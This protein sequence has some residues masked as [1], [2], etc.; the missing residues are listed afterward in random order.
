MPKHHYFQ[1]RLVY[2]YIISYIL[3]FLIPFVFMSLYVYYQSS[4]SLREEIESSNVNKLEQIESITNERIK[5]LE[6]TASKIAFS[7]QLTPYKISHRYYG[8]EAI[9]ELSNLKDNNAIIHELFIY[10]YEQEQLLYSSQGPYSFSELLQRSYRFEEVTEEELKVYL[11]SDIPTVMS[12]KKVEFKNGT[13]DKMMAF[14]YPISP[15]NP[16]PYGAI[17]YFVEESMLTNLT[18]N[19][20]GD[21]QGSTYIVDENNQ[22]IVSASNGE[23]VSWEQLNQ[24]SFQQQGVRTITIDNR[25]YSVSSITS[26][27]SGWTF[28]T[29]MDVEQFTERVVQ[30]ETFFVLLIV[31]LFIVGVILAII[32]GQNQYRPIKRL[33]SLTQVSKNRYTQKGQNEIEA[34]HQSITDILNDRQ[35]LTETLDLQEP[36]AKDQLLSH[37]LKGDIEREDTV[38][39]LIE[40][41]SMPFAHGPHF[42]IVVEFIEETIPKHKGDIFSLSDFNLSQATMNGVELFN[43]YLFAFIVSLRTEGNNQKKRK[44]ITRIIQKKIL[45]ERKI[46]IKVMAVGNYYEKITHINRSFIEAMA[47]LE[48]KLTVS[49]GSTIYF[50]ELVSNHQS[51][52]GYP[53]ESQMKLSQSL[54]EGDA[55]VAIETLNFIVNSLREAEVSMNTLRYICFD[56]INTVIKTAMELGLTKN[57]DDFKAIGDFDSMEQMQESLQM[58][59]IEICNRVQQREASHT[60]RLINDI[61][62]YIQKHFKDFELSLD[63]LANQFHLSVPYLSKFIK[64]Q[65]GVTFTEYVFQMRIEETKKLLRETNHPIK[66]IVETVGYKDVSNFTRRFKQV[67]SMT[68][69]QYRKLFQ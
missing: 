34:L 46:N 64:D 57:I 50:E 10:L 24:K 16:N 20:L 6:N 59:I 54:R 30:R 52:G 17:M 25:D 5:E 11:N 21:F 45:Q 1:P 58:V 56:I 9:E 14:T 33:A 8:G 7:P 23:E 18:E 63:G 28:I 41:L 65:T 66:L 12:P 27:V 67:E 68:P 49:Q 29:V 32:I 37:I 38:E 26:E 51:E 55:I 69:G 22:L 19:T 48:H 61:L 44:Q 2:R 62:T 39:Q 36:Y 31:I 13:E 43:P 15:S 47:S 53:Q 40:T 42:V 4:V 60:E 35:H 3:V